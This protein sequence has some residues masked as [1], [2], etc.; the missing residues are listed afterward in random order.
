MGLPIPTIKAFTQ[1]VTEAAARCC[2]DSF[3]F[4]VPPKLDPEDPDKIQEKELEAQRRASLPHSVQRHRVSLELDGVRTRIRRK[5]YSLKLEKQQ[6]QLQ[7]GW[8]RRT[9]RKKPKTPNLKGEGE[10]YGFLRLK[11]W[12]SKQ[13]LY[14]P[15]PQRVEG[16]FM[17]LQTVESIRSRGTSGMYIYIYIYITPVLFRIQ[18]INFKLT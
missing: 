1:A 4:D 14:K 6:P 18:L 15:F 7:R 11:I 8:P 17:G 12:S 5:I 16:S 9:I 3:V 10:Q 2:K 13:L